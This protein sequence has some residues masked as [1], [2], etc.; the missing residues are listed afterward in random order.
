MKSQTTVN[1]SLSA[2]KNN[3]NSVELQDWLLKQWNSQLVIKISA[4]KRVLREIAVDIIQKLT[5][6]I[7]TNPQQNHAV[8]YEDDILMI[9]VGIDC[10]RWTICTTT[11]EKSTDFVITTELDKEYSLIK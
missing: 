5:R 6:A 9:L 10:Q 4:N 8:R 3:L 1:S 7:R 11:K 2:I